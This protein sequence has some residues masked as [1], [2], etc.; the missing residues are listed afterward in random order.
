MIQASGLSKSYQNVHALQDVDLR[1]EEGTVTALLGHN[2]A[3]KTTLVNILSTLLPP[4]SGTAMVAGYDVVR[5]SRQVCNVIGLTGQFASVDE[6]L[7]GF[8]NLVLIARLLG[9]SRLEARRRADELLDMF[10]LTPAARRAA[11]TYSGGMRRRLDIAVSLVGRPRVLFLDEPSTGLDPASRISLWETVEGLVADGTTV[12]L[13]T[14]YLE[15]A[16]RL[17]DQVT[18]LSKGKVVAAGTPKELKAHVGE[19]RVHL[20]MSC[21]ADAATMGASL[22]RAGF[23][24][25]ESPD[26][27][28]VS[29]PAAEFTDF[30]D[31]VRT[32]ADTR[33]AV[34]GFS[35]SEPSLDDVYLALA[36]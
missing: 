8:D 17:A 12:L 6:S 28:T 34:V 13:T 20:T 23:N 16:E 7:S 25:I 30:A 1:V 24:A 18:V 9:A 33:A 32:A 2:G 22:R 26:D 5:Q 31:I 35:V 4:T 27:C 21:R 14:Q 10:G 11:R 29:V 3:G 19:R 36:R 15:E